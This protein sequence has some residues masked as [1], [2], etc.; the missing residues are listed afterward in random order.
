[1]NYSNYL[2]GFK[3]GN[4]KSLKTFHDKNSLKAAGKYLSKFSAVIGMLGFFFI[5]CLISDNFLS[6]LNIRNILS[7]A[8]PLFIMVTGLSFVILTGSIDLSTGAICS[9]TCVLVGIYI[10]DVGNRIF[11]LVIL[12]GIIA[13][14]LNGILVSMLKMPS[15]I[16]TLCTLSIFKCA[17]LVI[18]GSFSKSIPIDKWPIIEWS[19]KSWFVFPVIYLAALVV[20]LIYLF[21]ERYTS[22]GKSIYALGANA[23]AARM[24]GIQIEKAQI[25]AFL[26]SGIGSALSGAFY[27]LRLRSYGPNIGDTLNLFAIAAVVLGGT[28]LAGGKGTVANTLP[29]VITVI[30]LQSAMKI[31]GLDAYWQNIVFGI[32][33]IGA[34]Y[35]NSD[36]SG[37]G[38]IVVK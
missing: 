17:A 24:S 9:C 18:S 31:V 14:L 7:N 38:D 26:M 19:F 29:S 32:V 35:I 22:M 30:M 27:A 23:A 15:F 4:G 25:T 10:G 13:G 34:I 12:I 16:V 36:R 8:A 11:F 21:V 37:G 3:V 6:V 28:S 1:V 5:F 20:Y 33:L 2:G